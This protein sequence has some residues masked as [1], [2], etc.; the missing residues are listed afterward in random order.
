VREIEKIKVDE[1]FDGL[2]LAYITENVT[3]LMKPEE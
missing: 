3:G 2:R 1:N